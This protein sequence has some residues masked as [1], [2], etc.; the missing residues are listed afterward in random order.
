MRRTAVPN[1]PYP[2]R[3]DRKAAP[4]HPPARAGEPPTDPEPHRQVRE[5]LP[6]QPERVHAET[7]AAHD[8]AVSTGAHTSDHRREP[9]PLVH[10]DRPS[11]VHRGQHAHAPTVEDPSALVAGVTTPCRHCGTTLVYDHH[12][13]DTPG[14]MAWKVA[15]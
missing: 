12:T 9:T 15:E 7:T 2:N 4:H 11:T 10:T 5:D 1:D 8:E 14:S 6:H 13:V 3:P